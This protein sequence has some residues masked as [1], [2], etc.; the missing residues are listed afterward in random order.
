MRVLLL[1]LQ[2]DSPGLNI[3]NHRGYWEDG[4]GRKED[5]E[6]QYLWG[7]MEEEVGQ[8]VRRIKQQDVQV[9]VLQ[10]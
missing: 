7:R 6:R 10:H 5:Y 2:T 9:Q 3:L 8:E 4:G 1:G